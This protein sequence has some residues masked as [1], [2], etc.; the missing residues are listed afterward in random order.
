MVRVAITLL[1]VFLA[2][3]SARAANDVVTF[4]RD[5]AP[6]LWKNC[7]GCH[8]PGEVGPFSLLSYQDAAKRADFIQDVTASRRMPPWKAEPGFGEFHDVRRLSDGELETLAKWS[9]AGAPEGDP[10]DLPPLPGFPEGWQLGEPDV[11]LKMT[12][13]FDLPGDGPD[14]YRCFVLPIGN[15]TDRTVAAVEFRPGNRKVV[16]HAIFYLDNSGTARR[17][18][19][20]DSG[21]GYAS[22]G[23]PG[24]PPTGGLGGWAP[25]ASPR[26]LPDGVG[27]Y[28]RR[29]SDL[30]LQV[31][32][33]LSGKPET[34]QSTVGI[35]YTK[36]PA[37]KI[38]VGVPL[39]NRR[40]YIPAGEE[41]YRVTNDVT[42][43]VDVNA[44]GITP[45]MHLL[46]REM[47]VTATLP[48]GA[49]Q[50]LILIKDWDFNWQDQY[51]YAS[52]IKLPK[53][54]KLELEAY[55]DNSANNPQNPNNPPQPVRWGEQTTDE[56]CLCVVQVVT[57]NLSDRQELVRLTGSRLG[58]GL[59]GGIPEQSR[60]QLDALRR[61]WQSLG[62]KD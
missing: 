25:G 46:G 62:E 17:R 29:G 12:E 43:P 40:L 10:S 11:V 59:G 24:I 33:H 8:R 16:H 14:V 21:P 20:A 35:Y 39:L 26:F 9:K 42:L 32:Y 50:P 53:G 54:T 13:P 55:Y 60:P 48:D 58:L 49:R 18:D 6:I 38:V 19:E 28:L 61:W 44:I 1:L 57:D 52:P 7:A 30:V 23:G 41:H 3:G 31:H 15:E 45:H 37:T 56:M 47:Q 51:L 2:A 5:V 22:F 27:K 36:R 4:N 34:D